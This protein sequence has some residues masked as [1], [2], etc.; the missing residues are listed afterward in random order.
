[1]SLYVRCTSLVC[2][3]VFTVQYWLLHV[4]NKVGGILQSSQ[5]TVLVRTLYVGIVNDVVYRSLRSVLPLI[6]NLIVQYVL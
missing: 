1:M 6:P 3:N 4:Y 2:I 5:K